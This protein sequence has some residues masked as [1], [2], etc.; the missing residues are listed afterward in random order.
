MGTSS[1]YLLAIA[2]VVWINILLSGDNAMVI[3]MACRGL[4]ER[5]R[6]L[7]IAV[8]TTAAILLRVVFAIAVSWLLNVPYLKAVGGAMLLWIAIS[9]T[10]GESD[11]DHE[12]TASTKLWQ[13]ALTITVADA[14]MSLDNVIG[15][16]AVANGDQW[17][18]IPG[19]L[20]SM[21]LVVVGATLLTKLLIKYPIIVWAGAAMLGWVAGELIAADQAL[22]VLLGIGGTISV[23]GFAA[24]AAGAAF[25]VAIAWVRR[26]QI[27]RS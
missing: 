15:I 25:V 13:A 14:T 4:P 17:L 5:Q 21:P 6:T 18:F 11:A 7:G 24:A 16:A 20:L 23:S 3:A 12:V 1:A 8:G 2:E 9:L 19:L 26:R 27:G 10:Q 22:R